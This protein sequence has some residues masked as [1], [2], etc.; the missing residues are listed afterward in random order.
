MY[1]CAGI[2]HRH[3]TFVDGWTS[4]S[5]FRWLWQRAIRW[6]AR[7]TLTSCRAGRCVP[8]C[9]CA[10]PGLVL[11]VWNGGESG[12]KPIKIGG[13]NGGCCSFEA[14]WPI[15]RWTSGQSQEILEDQPPGDRR[16]G[17][18]DSQVTGSA[19]V[20][21]NDRQETKVQLLGGLPKVNWFPGKETDAVLNNLVWLLIC[22]FTVKLGN[23]E[24]KWFISHLY[25]N[26]L[27]T[28]RSINGVPRQ[29][30]YW[31]VVRSWCFATIIWAF[32][33]KAVAAVAGHHCHLSLGL[34][35]T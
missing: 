24:N 20:V 14:I 12:L 3:G 28:V 34:L 35:S 32:R 8:C 25:T 18:D 4:F 2:Q 33:T 10:S 15:S 23:F 26:H 1:C 5:I 30:C 7:I 31:R 27:P 6:R 9:R 13:L 22:N 21:L 29:S 16:A 19:K 17:L 11:K